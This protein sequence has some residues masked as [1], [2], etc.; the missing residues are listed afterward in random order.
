MNRI[1]NDLSTA[2]WHFQRTHDAPPTQFQVL[3]ERACGTNMIRK[4][5][6]KAWRIERTE[7]LGWKHAIPGMVAI[8]ERCVVVCV[9]R[10]V[11]SWARS[12]Y[13]RPWHADAAMQTLPFSEFIRAEWQSIV[14]RTGVLRWSTPRFSPTASP[15]NSTG[16]RLRDCPSP[17]SL[18]CAVLRRRRFW[19]CRTGAAM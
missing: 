19:V 8:P 3:G 12:L 1:A 14:D 6:E 11:F 9:Q 4:L 13:K 10:E 15:C 2:G 17:T 16:T 18:R 7:G 5:I